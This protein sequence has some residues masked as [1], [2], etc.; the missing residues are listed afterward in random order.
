MYLVSIYLPLTNSFKSGTIYL[1][2]AVMEYMSAWW[3]RAVFTLI[4]A[5]GPGLADTHELSENSLPS[6]ALSQG[7]VVFG[8]P[9]SSHE[10]PWLLKATLV[11]A[12][13]I[14]YLKTHSPEPDSGILVLDETT[15]LE[16]FIPG[17]IFFL[18]IYGW[19]SSQPMLE[20]FFN[21]IW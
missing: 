16:I 8:P 5:P 21:Q 2:T 18:R 1:Y 4:Q 17:P 10:D 3:V 11:H 7:Y 15:L 9:S 6:N 13:E 19:L 12:V 14:K 20:T